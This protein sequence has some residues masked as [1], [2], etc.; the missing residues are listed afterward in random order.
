MNREIE[1]LKKDIDELQ[2]V[3]GMLYMRER[4]TRKAL[5]NTMKILEL[6][7]KNE[8]TEKN[9]FREMVVNN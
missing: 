5:K 9:K 4:Q 6:Y 7:M 1:K 8:Q 2:Q 3:C